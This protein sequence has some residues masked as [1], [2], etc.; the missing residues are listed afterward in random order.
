MPELVA[1]EGMTARRL[2]D[3]LASRLLTTA[4]VAAF[5]TGCGLLPSPQPPRPSVA[6]GTAA[7]EVGRIAEIVAEQRPDLFVGSAL[8]EDPG[9]APTLYIKGLRD[10][11]IDDL[12]ASASVPIVVA[13]GQPYSF[14]ELEA[15]QAR[16]VEALRALTDQVGIGFDIERR[17]MMDVIVTRSARLPD[18]NAVLAAIPDDLHDSVAVRVV[19]DPVVDPDSP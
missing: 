15:R 19:D 1:G 12:V 7:S 6:F 8:S 18:A 16:V 17:G 11:F 3:Q 13:Y 2:G 4:A 5:V 9:G 14:D 10:S